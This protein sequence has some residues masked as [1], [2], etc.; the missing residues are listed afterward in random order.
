[1]VALLSKFP[2]D[3]YKYHC[4]YQDQFYLIFLK[5]CSIRVMR[6]VPVD[7]SVLFVC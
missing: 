3:K 1:M 5:T 2:S 4:V 7:S 6:G